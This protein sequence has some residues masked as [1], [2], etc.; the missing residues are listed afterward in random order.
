[1]NFSTSRGFNCPISL[2][3]SMFNT[4]R[5][6]KQESR[7][8]KGLG[9]VWTEW[10]VCIAFEIPRQFD[11]SI[12]AVFVSW[13]MS[14]ITTNVRGYLPFQRGGH[15]LLVLASS[16]QMPNAVERSDSFHFGVSIRPSLIF[17]MARPKKLYRFCTDGRMNRFR[18]QSIRYVSSCCLTPGPL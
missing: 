17:M 3:E 5:N 8:R 13:A 2:A 18:V 7:S 4:C 11:V 10:I 14:Y 9:Q 6:M 12:P 15:C 1:M 16:L